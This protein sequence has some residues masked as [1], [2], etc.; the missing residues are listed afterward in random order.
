MRVTAVHTNQQTFGTKVKIQGKLK[1]AFASK[2]GGAALNEYIKTLESNGHNDNFVLSYALNQKN[3]AFIHAD[4]LKLNGTKIYVGKS[5][6]QSISE[7][8][9]P[10]LAKMYLEACQNFHPFLQ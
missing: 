4:V 2:D 9:C 1:Q 10:N 5:V 6:T 3:H 8:E 7:N